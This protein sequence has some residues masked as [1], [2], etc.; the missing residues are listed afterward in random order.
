MLNSRSLISLVGSL[1]TSLF[2]VAVALDAPPCIGQEKASTPP[3]FSLNLTKIFPDGEKLMVYR[4]VETDGQAVTQTY[5]VDVPF[6]EN[7]VSKTRT[8]V[9]T[10]EVKPRKMALA[11]VLEGTYFQSLD[12]KRLET[13]DV[14]A[15]TPESGRY[16]IMV[17]DSNMKEI[18]A[19]WKELFKDDVVIMRTR[20]Q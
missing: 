13:K 14:A 16:V 6:S 2:F 3:S 19:E 4:Q 1:A 5:T 20:I 7:G 18:P 17:F 11:P 12:G 9:R 8:E 10:R 15:K